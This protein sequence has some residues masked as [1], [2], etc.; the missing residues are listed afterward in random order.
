MSRDII[1]ENGGINLYGM[2]ENDA[3]NYTDVMGNERAKTSP[4][5]NKHASEYAKKIEGQL[6]IMNN[7]FSVDPGEAQKAERWALHWLAVKAWV[8]TN[9]P[10]PHDNEWAGVL[11]KKCCGVDNAEINQYLFQ[12]HKAGI[13]IDLPFNKK[14]QCPAGYQAVGWYHSHAWNGGVDTGF[15]NKDDWFR[16][17]QPNLYNYFRSNESG[18]DDPGRFP[19]PED[20][21]TAAVSAKPY[22]P[23]GVQTLDKNQ[24]DALNHKPSVPFFPGPPAPK[25]LLKRCSQ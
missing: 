4:P 2:I 6:P 18:G 5:N 3:V 10:V 13:D 19:G 15:P 22:E 7:P 11:C 25:F 9:K 24:A 20:S 23:P 14:N 12:S 1:G 17:G 16:Y 8:A 21:G